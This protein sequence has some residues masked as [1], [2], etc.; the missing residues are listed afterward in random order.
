[1]SYLKYIF[2][3][4][5]RFRSEGK[6]ADFIAV[7]VTSVC[8]T[9]CIVLYNKIWTLQGTAVRRNSSEGNMENLYRVVG[10]GTDY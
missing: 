7:A 6:F 1:V 5:V 2:R 9:K 4:V 10:D 3:S 8:G